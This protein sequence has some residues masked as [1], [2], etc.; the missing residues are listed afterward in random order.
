MKKGGEESEGSEE[1]GRET[2]GR[3]RKVKEKKRREQKAGELQWRG[4]LGFNERA[5]CVAG[6]ARG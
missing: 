3:E 4:E 5:Q 6:K 1:K 2:D